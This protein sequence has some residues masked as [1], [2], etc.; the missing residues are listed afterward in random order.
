MIIACNIS[1]VLYVPLLT[2]E[3]ELI[4]MQF[5]RD[6][7]R[8]VLSFSFRFE[9]VCVCVSV[10]LFLC[11]CVFVCSALLSPTTGAIKL[12]ISYSNVYC[13]LSC[14]CISSHVHSAM[15]CSG[16]QLD[17]CAEHFVRFFP[18]HSPPFEIRMSRDIVSYLPEPFKKQTTRNNIQ[19]KKK[20]TQFTM[21]P[22]CAKKVNLWICWGRMSKDSNACMR[23]N[24]LVL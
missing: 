17:E 7:Y 3:S 5:S 12:N 8:I 20:H 23:L 4:I 22:H 21:S 19:I 11:V 16:Y 14:A 24:Y 9:I 18:A 10:C 1:S 13:A 15:F 6:A 2:I